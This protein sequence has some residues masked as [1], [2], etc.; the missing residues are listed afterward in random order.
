MLLSALILASYICIWKCKKKSECK[1]FK[2]N[3][4]LN[5][6]FFLPLTYLEKFFPVLHC[7][8]SESSLV[9]TLPEPDYIGP[10]KAN[11]TKST[12]NVKRN[13]KTKWP[14]SFQ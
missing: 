5:F 9:K 14:T 1:T 2:A 12:I 8:H 11:G 13:K 4:C 3:K 10:N 6:G 7:L